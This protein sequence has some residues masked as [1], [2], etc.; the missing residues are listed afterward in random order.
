[1]LSSMVFASAASKPEERRL[2]ARN[3]FRSEC[4][5]L[6]PAIVQRLTPEGLKIR[7]GV[8]LLPVSANQIVTRRIGLARKQRDKFDSTLALI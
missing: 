4:R 6:N 1:M 2:F 5:T 8:L 7:T 3:C